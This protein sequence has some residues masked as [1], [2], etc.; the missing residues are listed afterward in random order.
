MKHAI[1][2]REKQ[3]KYKWFDEECDNLYKTKTKLDLSGLKQR[4]GSCSISRKT[5]ASEPSKRREE[6]GQRTMD[7]IEK[8]S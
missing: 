5:K 6:Y 2:F 8:E 1:T 7:E 4:E 3:H